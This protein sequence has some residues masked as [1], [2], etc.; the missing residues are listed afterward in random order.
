MTVALAG[1][2]LLAA[3]GGNDAPVFG[4]PQSTSAA[5]GSASTESVETPPGGG[6]ESTE[7]PVSDPGPLGS[8]DFD[9]ALI[10]QAIADAEGDP[11]VGLPGPDFLA[12]ES[13]IS[14]FTASGFDLSGLEIVV[15]PAGSISAFV[16]M[17]TTD[18]T[19][20]ILDED[21]DGGEG[22]VTQLLASAVLT[23]FGVDRLIIQHDGLDDEGPFVMTL[24]VLVADLRDAVDS[25]ADLSDRI[26]VQLERG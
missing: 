23:E 10:E 20:L 1:V 12:T 21:D 16:L 6:T 25:G 13:L 15:Y 4:A 26:A 9:D 17:S 11:F 22:F 8:Y 18:S 5:V 19:A 14:E 24:S 7:Q 3:C 2:T